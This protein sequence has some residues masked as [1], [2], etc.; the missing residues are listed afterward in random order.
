MDMLTLDDSCFAG[1]PT[2][3][4]ITPYFYH[5]D[6][7][8]RLPNKGMHD[9]ITDPNS[10]YEGDQIDIGD[11]YFSVFFD[12]ENLNKP[13]E[14][15][16]E[17][18]LTLFNSDSGEEGELIYMDS[19][20]VDEISEL[21]EFQIPIANLGAGENNIR[22]TINSNNKASE[23]CFYNNN[24]FFTKNLDFNIGLGEIIFGEI[25]IKLYP[26]PV[27]SLLNIEAEETIEHV[28]IY[29]TTAKLLQRHEGIQQS[30]LQL[31]LN[32]LA[33]GI[34]FIE[35]K[36]ESGVVKRKFLKD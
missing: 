6:P 26:N 9:F 11:E 22:L 18:T 14:G 21:Q 16:I 35:V 36:C 7:A 24:L 32:D 4:V 29:S 30:S 12:V 10:F 15:M 25:P 33:V 23:Y 17:F 19:V 34:Y 27:Q 20:L 13:Y 1:M 5:G 28:E 3:Y 8:I 31:D 2:E